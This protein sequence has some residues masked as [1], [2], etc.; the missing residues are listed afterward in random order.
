MQLNHAIT[1]FLE[2]CEVGKNHSQKTLENYR[3]YLRRFEEFIKNEKKTS[4]F[5]VEHIS[6]PLV[7]RYRLFLNR[8]L[9]G[10]GLPLSKKTQSYHVIALRA[11]LKYLIKHDIKTLS[12]EK[13][14]LPKIGARSVEFLTRAELERLFSVIDLD[15]IRGYRDRA[16]METLYSTGLRVSELTALNRAHLNLETRE[17]G[18]RGKGD[19]PRV[20]FLSDRAVK[21][22]REYLVQRHDSLTPLFI[23]TKRGRAAEEKSFSEKARLTPVSVQNIVRKY[24]LK[25]GIVKK[26]TP[27]TLRHSFATELLLN[28]ADIRSVQELLGHSS[29][30]TTQVYTHVTNQKLKEVH[31]KFHR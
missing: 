14:D 13:I 22:L 26:V 20:V 9:D 30:T 3:H 6:L 23:N 25:A 19:K 5:T 27:H 1:D 11:M 31:E 2:Y 12:P 4:E 21:F 18:V 16:I 24:A 28:G 17:F 7:Q 29:I 15:D 8:Y 10:Y